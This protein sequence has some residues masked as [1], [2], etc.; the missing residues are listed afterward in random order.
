MEPTLDENLLR[1][2]SSYLALAPHSKDCEKNK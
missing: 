1:P 2:Y